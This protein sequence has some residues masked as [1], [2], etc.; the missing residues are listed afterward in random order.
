MFIAGPRGT[1]HA[2]ARSIDGVVGQAIAVVVVCGRAIAQTWVDVSL[3]GA[4][5]AVRTGRS[6]SLANALLFVSAG[7]RQAVRTIT[8][9]VR[10]AVTIVVV[11]WLAGIVGRGLG[12]TDPLTTLADGRPGSAGA[13]Q[14]ESPAGASRLLNACAIGASGILSCT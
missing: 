10:C 13:Q 8:S 12:A 5:L 14:A 9:T 11:A 7:L 6:A 4:P 3:A 2:R 1:R